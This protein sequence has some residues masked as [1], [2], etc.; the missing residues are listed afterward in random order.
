T[1]ATNAVTPRNGRSLA[2]S[3]LAGAG[4]GVAATALPVDAL[5]DAAS[6]APPSEPA[7]AP[8]FWHAAAA[9]ETTASASTEG[10]SRAR[11]MPRSCQKPGGD[12]ITEP[13]AAAPGRSRLHLEH[14]PTLGG[15]GQRATLEIAAEGVDQDRALRGRGVRGGAIALVVVPLQHAV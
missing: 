1:V 5:V 4:M 12:A 6:G 9:A 13:E 2:G 10:R 3:A 14:P 7:P 15:G 8:P 11:A